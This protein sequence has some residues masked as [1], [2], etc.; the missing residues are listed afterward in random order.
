MRPHRPVD[1][2]GLVADALPGVASSTSPTFATGARHQR[3]ATPA[4]VSARDRPFAA[5]GACLRRSGPRIAGPNAF[6]SGGGPRASGILC[7]PAR[8]LGLRAVA[9]AV[10]PPAGLCA[11]S[12]VHRAPRGRSRRKRVL[13]PRARPGVRFGGL[14]PGS[15]RAAC[16]LPL[17]AWPFCGAA[18]AA[19]GALVFGGQRVALRAPA[20]SLGAWPLVSLSRF[21][22]L[23][24]ACG[25]AAQG[26]FTLGSARCDR[27]TG[28]T[29]GPLGEPLLS[30]GSVMPAGAHA[31]VGRAAAGRIGRPTRA[32]S[33]SRARRARSVLPIVLAGRLAR[34]LP[35]PSP[36]LARASRLPRRVTR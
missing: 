22:R 23:A 33:P 13:P 29:L 5:G 21:L 28:G 27:V 4:L 32:R 20:P 2:W 17:P 24:S 7:P 9:R 10:A 3:F 16:R 15:F 25:S 26:T 34:C 11:R 1:P 14:L 31:W 36:R 6:P 18:P 35:L 30:L 12:G 19:L 8:P